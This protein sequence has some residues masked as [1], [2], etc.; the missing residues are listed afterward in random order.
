MAENSSGYKRPVIVLVSVL[1]ASILFVVLLIMTPKI[2]SAIKYAEEKESMIKFEEYILERFD[3][4]QSEFVIEYIGTHMKAGG[5]SAHVIFKDE[6]GVKYWIVIRDDKIGMEGF[7]IVKE[8][9]LPQTYTP[10]H[11]KDFGLDPY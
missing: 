3:V 6:P 10:A 9:K 7:Q 1:I 11:F 5:I 4:Q 2:Y 8:S